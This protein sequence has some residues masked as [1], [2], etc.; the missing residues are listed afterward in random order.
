VYVVAGG[1]QVT[2]LLHRDQTAGALDVVEVSAQPGG[3]PPPHSHAFGEWFRVLE[4]ELTICEDRDGTVV[5]T[6]V[7]GQGDSVW[8]RHGL[9]TA[10]STSPMSLRAS[11]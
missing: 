1:N 6:S 7:L 10:R 11:R 5:C 3:G 4:G 8:C 2:L 9:C